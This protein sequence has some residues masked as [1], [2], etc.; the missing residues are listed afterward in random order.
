[1]L[2]LP[3]PLPWGIRSPA[4]LTSETALPHLCPVASSAGKQE[5]SHLEGADGRQDCLVG[6]CVLWAM[7][8]GMLGRFGGAQ[9]I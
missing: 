6:L 9:E 8:R 2:K 1:M 3:E 7:G 4:A 5:V